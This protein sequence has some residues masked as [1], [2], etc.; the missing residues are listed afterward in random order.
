[1]LP[2]DHVTTTF[3]HLLTTNNMKSINFNFKRWKIV[4]NYIKA[5]AKR[6]KTLPSMLSTFQNFP[7]TYVFSN[8]GYWPFMKCAEF[9]SWFNLSWLTLTCYSCPCCQTVLKLNWQ[10]QNTLALNITINTKRSPPCF[11]WH[12]I[13]VEKTRCHNL[14][15]TQYVNFS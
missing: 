3:G 5:A 7:S 14:Q 4:N 2:V 13:E 1:M 8:S 6:L 12:K 9:S 10:P 15:Y 11:V